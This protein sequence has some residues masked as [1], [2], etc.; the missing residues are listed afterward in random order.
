MS[1]SKAAAKPGG[2]GLV[3]AVV[4]V[5]VLFFIW[6]L[7]T[8]LLDPLLKAM[9]TVFTLNNLEANLTGFAFFIAY[10]VM[11]FP[12]AALMSKIG[13]AKSVIVGLLGILVGCLI[14]LAATKIKVYPVFL[15]ALFTMASGVTLLQV[16]ANPLIAT[17]G[18][19]KSSHF[20]L[21]LSQAFNS[22]GAACGLFFGAQFL[23]GGDI[24]KPDVVVTDA[25]RAET[26]S[27]VG[28]VYLYIALALAAFIVAIW[29][30]RQRISDAAPKMGQTIS[31][32]LALKS[33]WANLGAIGIFLYVGAEVAI[34][35]NLLLFLEQS[36]ILNIP[37]Q[38]AGKLTTF[39]MLFAMIGRFA[40]SAF[41]R[42][43]KGYVMLGVFAVGAIILCGLI[44]ASN[45]SHP[46][47]LHQVMTVPFVGVSM[48][49]TTGVYI[50][51]AALLVGLFNSIMFPTIFTLTLERS[52][53]PTSATSGLLVMAI[54]GGAF[55]PLVFA[56]IADMT[57]SRQLGFIAPLICY[58]Y[59][60]WFAFA[61]KSAPIHAIDEDVVAG[62]H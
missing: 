53:A 32:F 11:S 54:V 48:E 17:L 14:A 21:N 60:L 62:G 58:I 36:N 46:T 31:P 23:L 61:S 22:L 44:I 16:A 52:T 26:L 50:G 18:D 8:N 37:A 3:L 42:F 15:V 27:F 7:V 29:M 6:A 43:V 9:K 30:V 1:E 25:L 40:G 41:L 2:S 34:S 39:Y 10:G 57:G 24:F 19:A 12:S 49:L 28:N 55:L 56:Q 5:T 59:V 38:M 35:L 33:K 47:D 45:G 4:Y 13:Y 51:F 20:R